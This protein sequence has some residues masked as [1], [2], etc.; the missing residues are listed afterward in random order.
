MVLI[1]S[2]EFEF[3]MAFVRRLGAPR[4]LCLPGD[5]DLRCLVFYI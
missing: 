4:V 1:A 3:E 5:D 2:N